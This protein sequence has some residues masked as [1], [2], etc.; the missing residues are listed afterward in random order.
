MIRFD[1]VSFAYPGGKILF[2]GLSLDVSQG[3]F[4]GVLGPNGAGKSTLLRLLLGVLAPT[5]GRIFVG[6]R[7]VRRT[8]PGELSRTLAAVTQEEALEFPFTVEEVVLLGRAARLGPLG[9]ERA[10]DLQAA[11]S[12]MDATGVAALAGRPLHALSGGERKRVLLA[13]A[14]AQDT[15]V[16]VLDEPAAALDI[17]HQVAI[18][19]LLAERNRGGLTIVV[20]AHDLN[21]AASYCRRLLLLRPGEPPLAGAVE[22]VL[23]YRRVREAFGVDVYV[24]VNELTGDRFLIPMSPR[25]LSG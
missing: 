19:D 15:P 2:S 4:L 1:D 5:T 21:L 14:L 11:A 12:A 8:P 24:G 9:F 25:K 22:D 17:H 13:R 6:G 7:D 20:V 23:T 3:E 10:E 16:L 18:F